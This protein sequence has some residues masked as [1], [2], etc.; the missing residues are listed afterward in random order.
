MDIV[1]ATHLRLYQYTTRVSAMLRAICRMKTQHRENGPSLLALPV[2]ILLSIR[3]FLPLSSAVCF[4]ISSRHLLGGLGCKPLHSLREKD[5]ASEKK[6][7]LVALERDL[8]SWQLCH[9]CLL[10]HPVNPSNGPKPL[11]LDDGKP[12]CVGASGVVDISTMLQLRYHQA[13]LIMNRYRSGLP[14]ANELERLCHHYQLPYS[15]SC[16]ENTITAYI[17]DGGLVILANSK[18]Q[19]PNGWDKILIGLRLPR[20]CRHN[21]ISILFP[22][23]TLTKTLL[24]RRSHGDGPP[25]AKCSEWKRCKFCLTSFLVKVHE[26]ANSETDIVLEVRTFL[27]SC[28][29]PL[30]PDWR[31]HC[32]LTGIARRRERSPGYD[33][34]L[35]RG[36]QAV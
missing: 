3:D 9:P 12:T 32:Y 8:P 6:R 16:V 13:Q 1:K 29:D 17:E 34:V 4:T 35:S 11:Y 26:S 18:L 33:T 31:N 10:F 22:D 19:L 5:H 36:C 28:K 30:D 25:C 21:G 14:Y 7:F 20:V 2:E 23:Q 15:N 24:C 27:G